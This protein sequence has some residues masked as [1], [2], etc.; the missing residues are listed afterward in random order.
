[1]PNGSNADGRIP[2]ETARNAMAIVWFPGAG[3]LFAIL[4]VQT[5][6]GRYQ[7]SVQEVW[8]WFQP[9]VFPTSAL[10]LGVIGATALQADSDKRTVRRFFFK[11]SLGLA[12]FYLIMLL[13]VLLIDPFAPVHGIE[14]FNL[15]SYFLAPLQSLVVAAIAVLFTS[16]EKT[17]AG[18]TSS[19]A[20]GTGS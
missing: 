16:Q 11:L 2:L 9:T 13:A 5:I 20:G 14:L 4:A 17:P 6:L 12:I 7:G 19:P 18:S 3:V 1:M 10:I 15:A 8:A